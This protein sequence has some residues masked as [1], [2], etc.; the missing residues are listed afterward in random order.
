MRASQLLLATMKETPADAEIVSHRLM[1]RA[2]MVRQL[3][4]GL[5][6]WLPLGVRVLRKVEAIVR[7]EMNRAGAQEVLMPSIQPANAT[8]ASARPTRKSSPTSPAAR[9]AAT[10]S[11]PATST[12]SRPSSVT[13]FGR[14]SVSCARVN[15]S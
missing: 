10:S 7:E 15:S 13:R 12:R 1:L 14:V 3:A 9:S 8:T 6:T 4:T 11:C 2:G 5:Y